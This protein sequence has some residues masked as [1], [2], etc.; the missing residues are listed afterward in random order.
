MARL[1]RPQNPFRWA[2]FLLRNATAL[3]A[4][5]VPINVS[6]LGRIQPS[7]SKPNQQIRKRNLPSYLDPSPAWHTGHQNRF[8]PSISCRI[9]FVP[10]TKQGCPFLR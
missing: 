2:A 3:P 5:S 7:Q 8:R 9:T 10:Q 1:R 6:C 4:L